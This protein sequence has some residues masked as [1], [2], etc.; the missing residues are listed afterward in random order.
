ETVSRV[1][2]RFREQG[3]LRIEGRYLEIA[4]ATELR[5]LASNVLND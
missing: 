4:D 3:V 5:R 1:L 2:T